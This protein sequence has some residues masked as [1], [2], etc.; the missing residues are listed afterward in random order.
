M[1]VAVE[2][3]AHGEVGEEFDLDIRIDDI[4][5]AGPGLV[6]PAMSFG[7]SCTMCCPGGPG[8]TDDC[9]DS[10]RRDCN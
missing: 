9:G 5:Q 1:G 8:I 6:P 10:N 7:V 3:F 2:E 4:D